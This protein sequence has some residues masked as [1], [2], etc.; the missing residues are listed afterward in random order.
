MLKPQDVLTVLKLTALK[1]REWRYSMLAEE[2]HMSPS[3]VHAGVKRL[4]RCGLVT[5]MTLS[6]GAQVQKVLLPDTASV[7]EFLLHGIRYVFPLETEGPAVGIPTS[8]GAVHI[9]KDTDHGQSFIPVWKYGT[10]GCSG[11]AVK[12]IYR[13]VPAACLDDFGLYELMVIADALRSDITNVRKTASEKLKI[14]LGG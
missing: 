4:V 10:G 6:S 11:I 1:N 7:S 9:F 13:S 8:Y 2:L 14:Y 5:E 3:E 12:P